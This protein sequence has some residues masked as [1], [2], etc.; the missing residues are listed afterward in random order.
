MITLYSLLFFTQVWEKVN[1]LHYKNKDIDLDKGVIHITKS[2]QR[3]N[4]KNVITSPKTH[5]SYRDV[6]IPQFLVD[7]IKQ[8][9]DNLYKPKDDDYIFMNHYT[10]ARGCK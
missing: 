7:I 1:C 8:Y 9:I 6:S 3:I 4:K 10:K 2:Y 5:N